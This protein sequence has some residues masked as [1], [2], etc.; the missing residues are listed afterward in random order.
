MR[1]VW[2]N[3]TARHRLPLFQPLWSKSL[4]HFWLSSN[5]QSLTYRELDEMG[6]HLAAYLLAKGFV[7]EDTIRIVSNQFFVSGSLTDLHLAIVYR[8]R[9]CGIYG[10]PQSR[11]RVCNTGPFPAGQ[12]FARY[13]SAHCRL[14]PATAP[15]PLLV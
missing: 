4:S 3:G 15:C 6:D 13:D 1:K 11:S 12:P 2:V 5:T 9:R 8:A 14:I 7:K 10:L